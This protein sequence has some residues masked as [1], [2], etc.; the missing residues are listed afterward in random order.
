M[1]GVTMKFIKE[2]SYVSVLTANDF[3]IQ[4]EIIAVCYA[5]RKKPVNTGCAENAEFL[6][7]QPD[8]EQNS[9]WVLK[10]V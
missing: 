7:V 4:C 3:M 1:H 5:I 6:T 8:G 10:G 2:K 9:T